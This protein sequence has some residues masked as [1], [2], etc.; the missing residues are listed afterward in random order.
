M[1]SCSQ[2]FVVARYR[3]QAVVLVVLLFTGLVLSACGGAGGAGSAAS[4]NDVVS[5]IVG[6]NGN[7]GANE[8]QDASILLTGRC[9]RGNGF[10]YVGLPPSPPSWIGRVSPLLGGRGI[11]SVPSESAALRAA[12]ELGY[13]IA[14]SREYTLAHQVQPGQFATF[15][16]GA[17]PRALQQ[18]PR[19]KAY[20]A[21]LQG[22]KGENGTFTVAGIAQHTYDTEGCGAEAQRILYGSPLLSVEAGYLPEDLNL[23]VTH[24]LLA[25]SSFIDATRRWSACLAQA[26][27]RQAREPYNVSNELLAS[28]ENGSGPVTPAQRSYEVKV[29]VADTR[30]QYNSGF[31]QTSVALRRKFA[32]QLSGPYEGLLLTLVEARARAS[33]KAEEVLAEA[34]R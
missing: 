27:G 23:A 25:D 10:T 16:S 20:Q 32:S 29:A 14:I 17:S 31:V 24:D 19:E 1:L 13:G 5:L 18:S 9:M 33:R 22:P 21:A 26:T 30:C 6:A 12:G 34:G 28:E 2:T 3:P 7:P 8:I 4:A 15:R 11:P